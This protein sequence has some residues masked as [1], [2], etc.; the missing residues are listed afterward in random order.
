MIGDWTMTQPPFFLSR[1]SAD[2]CGNGFAAGKLTACGR[3]SSLTGHDSEVGNASSS[4]TGKLLECIPRVARSAGCGSST[5]RVARSPSATWARWFSRQIAKRQ[6]A[7]PGLH[8]RFQAQPRRTCHRRLR[9][10]HARFISPGEPTNVIHLSH[11]GMSDLCDTILRL[12]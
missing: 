7:N 11:S 5:S 8:H 6:D 4:S 3:V 9:R 10:R 1:T 12:R 2:G